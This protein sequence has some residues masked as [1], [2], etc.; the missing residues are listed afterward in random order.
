[1]RGCPNSE[2]SLTLCLFVHLAL[3]GLDDEGNHSPLV[4]G[5][6]LLSPLIQMLISSGNTFTDTPRNNVLPAT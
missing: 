4:R 3:S 2:I 5:I 1:M 6:S